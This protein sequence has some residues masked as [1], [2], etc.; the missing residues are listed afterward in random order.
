MVILNIKPSDVARITSG[1]V[2]TDLV[3][4]L[5]ELVENSIDAESTKLEIIFKNNGLESIEVIDNGVGIKKEDYDKICLRHH[6]SKL[7]SLEHLET[8]ATLGFRGEA[9]ASLNSI[10]NL[11][12]TTCTKDDNSKA[13]QLKFTSMG[14]LKETKTVIGGKTGTHVKITDI[15]HNL[16]VRFKSL[17]KTIKKE[18]NK[19]ITLIISY[20]LIYPQ[21]RFSIYNHNLATGKK[22]LVMGTQGLKRSTTLDSL[23]A[24]FGSNGSYG[25]VPLDIDLKDLEVNF[26]LSSGVFPVMTT[27]N[28][29]F[30]GYISDKSFGMG[31]SS[32]DR[33]FVYINRR[34]VTNKRILKTVNEVYKLFNHTQFPVVVLNIVIDPQMLDINVTP[35][36]RTV[37]IRHEDL[38]NDV[39]REELSNFYNSLSILIPKNASKSSQEFTQNSNSNITCLQNSKVN[40]TIASTPCVE[41]GTL[42]SSN[43]D[44]HI[45]SSDSKFCPSENKDDD[46][47][48]ILATLTEEPME[49]SSRHSSPEFA[50]D[51]V[52]LDNTPSETLEPTTLKRNQ[53]DNDFHVESDKTSLLPSLSTSTISRTRSL[54]SRSSNQ[55]TLESKLQSHPN[56]IKRP[57]E[58]P[59]RS[60]REYDKRQKRHILESDTHCYSSN[61]DVSMDKIKDA[62]LKSTRWQVNDSG[63]PRNKIRIQNIE[64]QEE[65]E[66][67]MSYTVSKEDFSRMNIIGQFNLGFILVSKDKNLFIVDQHASDEK[68]NYEKLMRETVFQSQ[69]LVAPKALDL[70]VI[71]E[72]TVV[73]HMEIFTKNGF[74]LKYNPDNTP[75]KRIHLV[76][77][78]VS[79]N[80]LFSEDDLFEL[81]HLIKQAHSRKGSHIK[82]SKVESMLAMRACRSSIM[83]GQH[84]TGPTMEKVVSNLSTLD[85]PWNCPHG[86]PTMRHLLEVELYKGSMQDYEL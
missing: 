49:D 74:V 39:L 33:Q 50:Q 58:S 59:P 21:I 2:I 81:I 19:A 57:N 75:G 27:L 9:L 45:S 18:Y 11:T 22:N 5:K 8:V 23:L 47:A 6:T 35:D 1:Q 13:S 48:V 53:I 63:V 12:L 65:Q 84:L 42:E 3:S 28:L 37:F 44:A 82:C 61:I 56:I 7:E 31:R 34:P 52:E 62:V 25:L 76:S 15:F 10:A 83:I 46:A 66:E 43:H 32:S 38:I 51:R 68:F 54:R 17:E 41:E 40:V 69:R 16:P 60:S 29:K 79:K 85:K 26:R 77:L 64:L 71:D 30:E 20:L 73:D 55:S 72:M 78:P 36:K 80:T 86:R 4:I 67:R 70:N 24:V 14:E